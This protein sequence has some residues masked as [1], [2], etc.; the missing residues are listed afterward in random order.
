[1]QINRLVRA[2]IVGS[3]ETPRAVCAQIT[4]YTSQLLG[5]V[6]ARQYFYLT[7]GLRDDVVFEGLSGGAQGADKAAEDGAKLVGGRFRAYSPWVGYQGRTDMIQCSEF[8]NWPKAQDICREFHPA[9][10]RLAGRTLS[11]LSRDSYQ[12]LGDGLVSPVD[13]VLCWTPDG[14]DSGGTG[15]AIRIATYHDIPVFNLHNPKAYSRLHKFLGR[16]RD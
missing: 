1:M 13:F 8:E 6:Y 15:Q 3:R 16:F 14:K 4:E 7:Q 11:L 9:P 10:D 2:A 12:I 5:S